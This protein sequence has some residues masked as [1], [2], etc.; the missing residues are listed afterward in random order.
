MVIVMAIGVV[1]VYSF[2]VTGIILK[3]LDLTDRIRL[4]DSDEY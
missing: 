3:V 2:V 1:A 4:N